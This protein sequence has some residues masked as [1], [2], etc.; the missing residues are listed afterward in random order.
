MQGDPRSFIYSYYTEMK[1]KICAL[2]AHKNKKFAQNIFTSPPLQNLM[3]RPL[4]Y[5]LKMYLV[6]QSPE[7]VL[8][9]LKSTSRLYFKTLKSTV[10]H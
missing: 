2:R 4:I 10:L 6:V 3:G 7:K 8:V 1:Y 5:D 9:D